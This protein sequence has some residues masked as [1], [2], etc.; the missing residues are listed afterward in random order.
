MVH[1]GFLHVY[2]NSKKE[3]AFKQVISDKTKKLKKKLYERKTL[4][5]K[6]GFSKEKALKYL[7][8]SNVSSTDK[9]NYSDNLIVEASQDHI[10]SYQSVDEQNRIND[11]TMLESVSIH[12]KIALNQIF[13][14]LIVKESQL[15]N[16]STI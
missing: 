11:D 6:L 14:E 16:T 13:K 3:K 5:L 12:K 9:N 7:K 15:S 10:N 4:Y 8:E 1:D 2:I